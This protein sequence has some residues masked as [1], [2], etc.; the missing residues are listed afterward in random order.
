MLCYY[1][2]DL[3]GTWFGSK[4]W[5]TDNQSWGDVETEPDTQTDPSVGTNEGIDVRYVYE[6]K[7]VLS[8]GLVRGIRPATPPYTE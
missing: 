7:P 2:N 5:E 1:F 3:T 4:L 8:G 6:Y